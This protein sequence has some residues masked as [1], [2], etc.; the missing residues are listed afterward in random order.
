MSLTVGQAPPAPATADNR[1]PVL[2]AV[3]PVRPERRRVE[4]GNLLMHLAIGLLALM[5]LMPFFWVICASLKH[6]ADFFD[7]LF[8][9][10]TE[11]HKWT[12][13]NYVRLFRGE[14]F[15][16]WM[17]N[18]LFL[19]SAHTTIVV[20]LSSLG[21]FALAKYRFPGKR[22][23]MFMMLGTMLLPSQVLLPSSYEL[24]YHLGWLDTY[25][26][27]IVP[28][29]VSVFGMF[30]FMQAMRAVPDELLQAGRVDGCSELRLWWEV[31]LPIVRPMIGAYTLLSFMGSWNSFLWPQ[32]VLQSSEH[33]TLPI[34]LTNM[35]GLPEYEAPYGMLMAATL[36][37]ILPIAL[38]F[39]I[40][41]KDFIAGLTSGAVK[42]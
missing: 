42:G 5:F 24:M 9:P 4:A 12:I 38:L 35:I 13:S 17:F 23:L 22:P 25:A 36:L 18:S 33:F 10:W 11:P 20:T 27:I 26:A 1:R 40:L 7:Y 29:A 28:S 3:P 41:Q 15:L 14:P 32:I 6:H 31:A 21:G 19:A 34:G 2:R 37:S 8:L 16:L 30:L 39:F